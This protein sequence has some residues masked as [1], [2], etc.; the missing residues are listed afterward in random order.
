MSLF[1]H[2]GSTSH[3]QSSSTVIQ[4][5]NSGN[6]S[7]KRPLRTPGLTASSAGYLIPEAIRKKF[8]GA[9]GWK[10]H[11]PLQFLTDKF[12]SF[13]N[14]ASSKELNDFFAVDA[15]AG[16]VVSQEKDL[17][18]EP[19]LHLSF[20]EWFQAWGRLLELIKTYVEEEHD[21][22]LIHFER[23][24]HR[25]NRAQHW[26]LCLEY[27]SQIRRRALV[28]SIDPAEFHSDVWNDL[29]AEHIAKRAIATMRR[30]FQSSHFAGRGSAQATANSERHFHPYNPKNP[31][32]GASNSFRN[33]T[34]L[35]CFFCGEDDPNHKSRLCKADRL[36]NGKALI[37][38]LQ[39]PGVARKDRNGEAYC[40][41]FNGYSGCARGSDCTNGK[42][43]CS[44][45]GAKNGL[46]SAQN[47][48]SL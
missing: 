36:T 6:S 41:T 4:P 17:A 40:Y 9:D 2:P 31:N 7:R 37:L 38:A 10:T 27:D 33:S 13:T 20:D 8:S 1:Y 19:E 25:P 32:S 18:L 11:V 47:C 30:E 3:N 14:H 43:W 39:K 16:N 44:L 21:M 48:L 12:C 35:R 34:K 24:L 22:W 23:I 46:H 29:E 42:H 45:C 26:A 15:S 5:H 28:T